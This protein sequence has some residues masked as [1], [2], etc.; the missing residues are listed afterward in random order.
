M[1]TMKRAD[2]IVSLLLLALAPSAVPQ[3]LGPNQASAPMGPTTAASTPSA[4]RPPTIAVATGA[5]GPA[6]S[7]GASSTFDLIF[8]SA[9]K[10]LK[11]LAYIVGGI[12][13]YFNY[14]KGRTHKP[15]LEVNVSLTRVDIQKPGLL[16]IIAKAKN[17]GLSQ[18]QIIEKGTAVVIAGRDATSALVDW[19]DL[20][21]QS[22]FTDRHR[23]IEPGVTIEDQLLVLIDATKYDVFK[24]ELLL[25]SASGDVSWIAISIT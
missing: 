17:V 23:W 12:W 15:R 19:T 2:L 18:V 10:V 25:Q 22:V 1:N 8:D 13:V 11:V 21:T 4:F 3:V 7:P 6:A 14:F 5:V 20:K 24:A 16:R 9:E